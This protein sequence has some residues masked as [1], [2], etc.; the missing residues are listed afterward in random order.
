MR[1]EN[2][3]HVILPQGKEAARSRDIKLSNLY[4]YGH[5]RQAATKYGIAIALA[6][7]DARIR[8]ATISLWRP[9]WTFNNVHNM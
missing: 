6:A 3:N 4:T 8:P 1:K 7:G 5:Q 2:I 9:Q